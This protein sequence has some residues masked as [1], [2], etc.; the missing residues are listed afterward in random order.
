MIGNF[1]KVLNFNQLFLN[2]ASSSVTS[3]WSVLPHSLVRHNISMLPE[4]TVSLEI[5]YILVQVKISSCGSIVTSHTG[6]ILCKVHVPWMIHFSLLHPLLVGYERADINLPY[7]LLGRGV[8]DKVRGPQRA[9]PLATLDKN[10]FWKP[11]EKCCLS[12]KNFF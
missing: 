11:T 4:C 8:G 10:K 9:T 1:P 7:E 3:S 12:C 6:L 5:D 2:S